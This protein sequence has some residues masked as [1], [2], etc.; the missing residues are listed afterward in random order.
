FPLV[1]AAFK[2]SRS[3]SL[4]A[5]GPPSPEVTGAFCR[6]PKPRFSRSPWYS[7]P[8]HLSRF[9][10][11]AAG[12]SRRCFSRQHRITEFPREG[13]SSDLRLCERRI[14]L[15]LAL[16]PYTRTTIAWLSYQIGR[17]HV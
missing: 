17:A 11:R 1:S 10:V 8:D 6:V 9:G 4:H 14:C 3:K 13:Y 2:R 7:L 5:S 15:S 16:R 12:T